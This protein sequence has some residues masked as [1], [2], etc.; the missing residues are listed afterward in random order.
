[1]NPYLKRMLGGQPCISVSQLDTYTSCS[2]KYFYRYK[3]RALPESEHA[4]LLFGNALH[5]G[6]TAYYSALKYGLPCSAQKASDDVERYLRHQFKRCSRIGLPITLPMRKGEP[7]ED[8]DSLVRKGRALVERYIAST[9][10]EGADI[11]AIEEPFV[12]PLEDA[13]GPIERPLAGEFDMVL[14]DS[15]GELVVVDWKTS[16]KGYS[17]AEVESNLQAVAYM[18]AA[19]LHFQ[20]E[21]CMFRFDVL[22]KTKEPKVERY[23]PSFSEDKVARLARKVRTMLEMVQAGLFLP[24]DDP[25]VCSGCPYAKRCAR[26]HQAA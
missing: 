17:P 19:R 16:D 22:T 2:L 3:E 11:L 9:P 23:F 1:M 10:I 6:L 5:T 14:R 15:N 13:R 18:H 20:T 24:V 7:S 25:Q 21:R 26:W 12:V 4:R 8:L